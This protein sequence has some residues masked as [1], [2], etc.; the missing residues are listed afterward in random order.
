MIHVTP[1]AVEKIRQ[2]FEKEG[3]AGGLRIAVI[4]GGCSG[5]S[6]Q[7]KFE[8]RPLASDNVFESGGVKVFVDPK[9]MLYLHGIDRKS[10]V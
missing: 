2:S 1:K 5:L 8:P 7:I 3:V 4:G 6:Y 9:S 10:V